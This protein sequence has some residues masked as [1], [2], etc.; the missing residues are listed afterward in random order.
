MRSRAGVVAGVVIAA[1]AC[2]APEPAR[3]LPPPP[4]RLPVAPAAPAEAPVASEVERLAAIQKA[5][6]ELDEA[7]QG[8]WAA[9]ATE[10]LDIAG[11]LDTHIDIGAPVPVHAFA[12]RDTLGHPRLTACAIAVLTSYAWAPPLYGQS[13]RLPF[14]FRAPAA[15]HV[16]D[17]ELVSW[18]RQG[19]IGVAV[20]LDERNTGN[21]AAS[22]FEVAIAGGATTG[23]RTT[24]RDE[25]WLFRG[26]ATVQAVGVPGR[27][28]VGA[29]DVMFV[30]AGG[31]REVIARAGDLRAVIV[32]VPG[33]REGAA[34][35]GALPTPPIGPVRA[36][37]AGPVHLPAAAARGFCLGKPPRVARGSCGEATRVDLFAEPRAIGGAPLAATV[38]DMPAGAVVP[39]HVHG[40]E[41]ELLYVLEGSGTMTVAGTRIAVTASSVVQVP[42][43]TPHAFEA[44]ARV[45]ALQVYTPAGPEQRFKAPP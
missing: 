45:R 22:M 30:P 16:I 21:G 18:N 9:A 37:P 17:R 31:A 11:E 14:R 27:R 41:T 43:S 39:E 29:G 23:M 36:A 20:L 24:A 25:L 1:A 7:M 8:C 35:A 4:A 34:R 13:I 5:M 10:R 42:P 2:G 26:A 6:N 40:R 19:A 38:L 3:P 32:V 15:Q 44:A 28:E 33:G 12:V